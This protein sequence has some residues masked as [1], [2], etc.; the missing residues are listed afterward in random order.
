MNGPRGR[1][2]RVFLFHLKAV[3]FWLD[4][5]ALGKRDQAEQ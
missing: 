2:G 5:V 3:I 4:R 1:A